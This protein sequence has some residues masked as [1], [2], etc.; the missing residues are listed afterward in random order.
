MGFSLRGSR[1]QGLGFWAWGS[2]LTLNQT[3]FK[4]FTK[5]LGF[6]FHGMTSQVLPERIA[7]LSLRIADPCTRRFFQDSG[8]PVGNFHSM[9]L[10][11]QIL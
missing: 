8:L 3:P 5:G 7:K 2:G 1:V 11:S 10:E 4:G 6:G 9:S